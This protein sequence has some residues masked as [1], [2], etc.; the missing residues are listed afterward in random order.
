MSTVRQF[1]LLVGAT[2]HLLVQTSPNSMA[3]K[4]LKMLFVSCRGSLYS[5]QALAAYISLLS[6]IDYILH[7]WQV[8]RKDNVYWAGD[9]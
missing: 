1:P 4:R 9:L 6:I 3:D 2:V 5:H 7:I 8:A